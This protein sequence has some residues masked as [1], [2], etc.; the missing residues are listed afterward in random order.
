[1]T[2]LLEATGISVRFGGN[3]AVSEVD[4]AVEEGRITGLIGPNGAGKTTT[5]NALCGLQET[6][7]GRVTLDGD[8]VT[9]LSTH[10]RAR[11]GLAR[12]F[13]R[14]EVF[15]S[16][17][18]WENVLVSA[19][20]RRQWARERVD[21]D[22]LDELIA[23]VGLSD[24][25]DERADQLP[26]GQCRLLELARALATK[27]RL[28][29]LDEPASGQDESETAA[30]ADLLRQLAGG[31]LA[32]LMVEH[33]IPL[34]M[35]VCSMLYVLDFGQIIGAG[36]PEEIRHDEKVLAAYLGTKK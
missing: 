3:L 21:R 36:P 29:L 31:G 26:T 13:Q 17:T 22:E 28:L 33:D 34:V 6:S 14:L 4:L 2:A 11:R 23:L 5:F 12:T 18:V 15:S 7:G 20:I 19:E 1:M 32:I 24:R 35:E 10:Q 27:P 9:G 16:M 25:R 30:F 8:D